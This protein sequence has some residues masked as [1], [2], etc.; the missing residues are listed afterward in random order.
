MRDNEKEDGIAIRRANALS[1]SVITIM[2]RTHYRRKDRKESHGGEGGT[3][4]RAISVRAGTNG[5]SD[6]GTGERGRGARTSGGKG[7]VVARAPRRPRYENRKVANVIAA[8]MIFQRRH[9]APRLK[10]HK[11]RAGRINVLQALLHRPR[12]SAT[13]LF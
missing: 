4:G 7:S 9:F 1:P 13:V 3:E 6:E 5:K 11:A 8:S 12:R 2:L 10:A